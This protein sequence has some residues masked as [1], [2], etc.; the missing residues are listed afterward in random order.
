[1]YSDCKMKTF[2]FSDF[3]FSE[4]NTPVIL[5]MCSIELQKRAQQHLRRYTD[6][7]SEVRDLNMISNVSCQILLVQI[8]TGQG[9]QKEFQKRSQECQLCSSFA[10]IMESKI[11]DMNLYCLILIHSRP[12]YLSCNIDIL[13]LLLYSF[14]VCQYG[15]ICVYQE[16]H[17]RIQ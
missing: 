9:F 7:Q 2:Y 12:N 1:M 5:P 6:L 10:K 4:K 13:F 15:P 16:K 3:F 14:T 11:R 17:L 8:L